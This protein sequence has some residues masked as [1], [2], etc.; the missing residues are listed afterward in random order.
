M[1]LSA[2][3][4]LRTGYTGT[5]KDQTLKDNDKNKDKLSTIDKDMDLTY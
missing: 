2:S 5:C 3:T 1:R 4:V